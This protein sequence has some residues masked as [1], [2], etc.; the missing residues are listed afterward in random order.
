[1]SFVHDLDVAFYFL[2]PGYELRAQRTRSHFVDAS[3][4]L[5]D[6]VREVGLAGAVDNAVG[7][8]LGHHL[9]SL[10]LATHGR[11]GD[12]L[13]EHGFA[14][15]FLEDAFSAGHLVMTDATWSKGNTYARA[16]HDF[17]NASGLRVKRAASAESCDALGESFEP[18]LPACWTT[19]GDG[20]LG[21]SPDATDRAHVV[22]A[23]EKAELQLAMAFDPARVEA[24]FV[25]LGE[26]DQIAFADLVDPTPWWTLPR[27]ARRTRPGTAAY[28]RRV[29]RATAAALSALEAE[30]PL[31]PVDIGALP[32][33]PLLAPEVVAVAIDPCVPAPSA[34]A[35]M[36]VRAEPVEH[37][38]VER[39]FACG[40]GR[41]LALGSVGASLLR[42]LLVELPEAQDDVSKLEGAAP[43][44]HGLAFQLLA[45]ASTGALFPRSAPVDLFVPGLG[46]SLG[47][48]YRFGTYLPGRRNRAAFEVNGGISS[49]LHYDARGNAGSNPQ[50]TMLDQEIRWPV[51]WEL[52]TSYGLPLDLR[53]THAAGSYILLGGARIHEALVARTPRLWG[54]DVEVAA[55]ALSSGQ[56]AYPLYSVSPELR[57]HLG[58]AD[59]SVVQPAL[60]ATWGP[61]ISLTLSGGYATLF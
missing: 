46:V 30:G 14:I 5:H 29:V 7:Q 48:A 25:R 36:P 16:R 49:S 26:R 40:P 39:E 21:V 31:R 37:D 57:F 4:P 58:L 10:Q 17:F 52:L 23:L 33:G 9:R 60:P 47:L 15:H 8:F 44:D 34:A 61:T 54:A 27:S 35:P 41:V 22:R 56:G 53:K 3:R 38:D 6:L 59:P 12:A 24:F 43:N 50:V 51:A 1:M 2:D 55:L 32:Q 45:S 18:G 11:A 20:H 13:L 28:A 19:T 42:P